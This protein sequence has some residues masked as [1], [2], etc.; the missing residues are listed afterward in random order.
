MP[1]QISELFL[2]RPL[3]VPLGI[4]SQFRSAFYLP[5]LVFSLYVCQCTI[6]NCYHLLSVDQ[7]SRA[8][9]DGHLSSNS[10]DCQVLSLSS[11][12]Q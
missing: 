1:H 8:D 11:S 6:S 3:L 4:E 7:Y 10:F 2:H 5:P 9:G 12:E